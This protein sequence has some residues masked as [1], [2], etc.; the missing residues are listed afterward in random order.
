MTRILS[1]FV[2]ILMLSAGLSADYASQAVEA[3]KLTF[4]VRVEVAL[5]ATAINIAGEP[6][7]TANHQKRLELGTRVVADPEAWAKLFAKGIVAD[8]VTNGS[9]TDAQIQ[10]RVANIWNTYAGQ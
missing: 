6:V 1:T 8:L 7:G 9:S 3:L 5:V 2:I 10:T 4:I